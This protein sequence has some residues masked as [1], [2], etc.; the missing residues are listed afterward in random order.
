MRFKDGSLW[1]RSGKNSKEVTDLQK[2]LVR[3]LDIK[4]LAV[5]HVVNSTSSPGVDGVKW[6]TSSE[7]MRAALSLTS[8]DYH[9]SPMRQI[10]ITAKNTGKERRPQLPTYHDRAMSVLYGYSLIP[11]TEA[12]AERKSFAFRPGRSA[13]DAHAYVLEA[14]K[15]EN[16]PKIIVCADIKA[17]S[18]IQHSWLMKHVP[19]D[20]RIEGAAKCGNHLRWRALSRRGGR[21]I[22]R[23]QSLPIPGELCFRWITESD[24]SW[25][26]WA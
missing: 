19:M 15:G 2:R 9:A 12:T 8:K 6:R 4:C 20:K 13:Q 10:L 24:L 1:Q 23:R 3:D 7:M 16:A 22:G 11:V 5:R 26:P 25:D 18:H 14:L 21:Y 17:Y